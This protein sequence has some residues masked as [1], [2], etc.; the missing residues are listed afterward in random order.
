MH[1]SRQSLYRAMIYASRHP[2]KEQFLEI[3]AEDIARNPYKYLEKDEW[4][5]GRPTIVS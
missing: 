1:G 4:H 5:G 3:N 2:P